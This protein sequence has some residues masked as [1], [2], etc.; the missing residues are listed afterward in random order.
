MSINFYI[1]SPWEGPQYKE[2]GWKPSVVDFTYQYAISDTLSGDSVNAYKYS[3]DLH[4][5]QH[6]VGYIPQYIKDGADH[7]AAETVSYSFH[8]FIN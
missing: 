4:L 5:S 3:I 1:R 2:D 6:A 7:E 8:V